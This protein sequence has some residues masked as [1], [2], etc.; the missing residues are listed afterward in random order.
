MHTK[1]V[2]M[3]LMYHRS[4]RTRQEMKCAM[5][6]RKRSCHHWHSNHPTI[7]DL[8]IAAWMRAF[9]SSS[10]MSTP[11]PTLHKFLVYAPDKTEAGT[12]EKRLSVRPKHV[13]LAK[14]HHADGSIRMQ[15]SPALSAA[16]RTGVRC[17][18]ISTEPR[19][20]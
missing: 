20:P 13:E 1:I 16:N 10:D 18:W 17:R 9:P 15:L 8:I 2:V 5:G 4:R 19:I 12:L 6:G 14:E 7:A 3:E 11:T